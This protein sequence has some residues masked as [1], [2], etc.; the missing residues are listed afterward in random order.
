MILLAATLAFFFGFGAPVVGQTSCKLIAGGHIVLIADAN[1]PDVF[2]WNT[3]VSLIDYQA[4]HSRDA[5]WVLG[6]TVIARAGT[7]AQVIAC[8]PARPQRNAMA[9]AVF[10]TRSA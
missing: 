8:F 7:P 9:T 10:R 3:R 2:V 1:D 6:H 4:G 5:H